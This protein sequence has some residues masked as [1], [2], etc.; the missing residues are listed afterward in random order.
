M[1]QY[2]N[3][4]LI[5]PTVFSGFSGFAFN[6]LFAG[7]TS[8]ADGGINAG[9]FNA[10][11]LNGLDGWNDASQPS[12]S[13][14]YTLTE[15]VSSTTATFEVNGAAN[16]APP[17]ALSIPV[18]LSLTI[19]ATST[20]NKQPTSPTSSVSPDEQLSPR[21]TAIR[22]ILSPK[23]KRKAALERN[24]VAASR[25]RARKK[26]QV[27]DL[28]SRQNALEDHQ[29]ELR[30]EVSRLKRH[31]DALERWRDMHVAHGC[32]G[33]ALPDTSLGTEIA[34]KDEVNG[35]RQGMEGEIARGNK[36]EID[37]STLSKGAIT[38]PTL[39]MLSFC[40]I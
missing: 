5:S 14:T 39:Y 27:V 36:M 38:S 10:D 32:K 25:C 30:A 24:R 6:D 31:L 18:D 8:L 20:S 29:A 22:G 28:Q 16:A 19:A 37:E 21:G 9:S 13:D 11:S 34:K 7:F 15:T 17:L 26:A 33:L 23:S 12:F 4:Y 3:E 2:E 35:E 40:G 1:D